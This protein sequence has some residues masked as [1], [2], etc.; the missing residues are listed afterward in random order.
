MVVQ[1]RPSLRTT[2]HIYHLIQYRDRV[3]CSRSACT[4]NHGVAGDENAERRSPGFSAGA[5]SRYSC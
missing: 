5:G 4:V 2:T 3:L 1:L